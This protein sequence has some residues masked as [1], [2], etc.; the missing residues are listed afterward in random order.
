MNKSCFPKDARAT[1]GLHP[2]LP[3][4]TAE[5]SISPYTCTKLLAQRWLALCL[6]PQP[7]PYPPTPPP[8]C[9][10]AALHRARQAGLPISD[11]ETLF[12]TPEDRQALEALFR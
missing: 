11:H 6:P 2:E 4:S 1:R 9:L 12:S 5:S 7:H 10:T 3:C 8:C